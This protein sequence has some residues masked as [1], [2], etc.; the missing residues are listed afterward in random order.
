V[1]PRTHRVINL[2]SGAGYSVRQVVEAVRRATGREVPV[3]PAPRRPGD[4]AVLVASTARAAAEL[5]WE[6]VRGLDEMV[7]DAWAFVTG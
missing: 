5:G 7:A 4:P 6:P 1:R 3:R 2:G